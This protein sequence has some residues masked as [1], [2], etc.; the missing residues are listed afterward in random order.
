MTARKWLQVALLLT[1]GLGLI[2]VLIGAVVWTAVAQSFGLHGLNGSS[3]FS[4]RFWMAVSARD[5]YYQSIRYSLY[6]GTISAVFSVALAYPLA[7]WLRKPFRGSLIIGAVLRAPLLV[8]GLVAAFLLINLI[9]YHGLINQAMQ[10]LALWDEPHNLRNDEN[11]LGV[12]ILQVWKN[13]PF[14][15]LLLTG[16]V[17]GISDDVLDAARDLGAGA[18][19]RFH[20]VI[21]PLSV[22]PMQAALVIIFIGALADFSF[23]VI[24]GPT[25][26]QSLA[27]LMVSYKDQGDWNSA[28]VV[29]VSLM[30][31]AL[32]GSTLLA[33][34]ARL[35]LRGR[36]R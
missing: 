34:L 25:D 4:T 7:M 9:A 19:S 32:V 8:H 33:A 13:M 23:P 27:Q 36:L 6:I 17:Q 12:L 15:L 22:A 1:P 28:A 29:G 24:A 30:L 5:A 21:T 3:L 2:L 16:A 35:T 14:A 20:R 10:C 31:L 18:W 26:Q 11:A